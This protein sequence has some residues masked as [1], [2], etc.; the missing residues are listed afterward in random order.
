MFSRNSIEL[1]KSTKDIKPI[2]SFTEIRPKKTPKTQA[3]LNGY[4][5]QVTSSKHSWENFLESIKNI[6]NLS[7]RTV[8]ITNR[9]IFKQVEEKVKKYKVNREF[10]NSKATNVLI[11]SLKEIESFKHTILSKKNLFNKIHHEVKTKEA[12]LANLLGKLEEMNLNDF[13]VKNKNLLEARNLEQSELEAG[14][15]NELI[16]KKTLL[17]IAERIKTQNIS[18]TGPIVELR[19]KIAKVNQKIESSE[20]KFIMTVAAITE[21]DKTIEAQEKTYKQIIYKKKALV[22]EKADKYKEKMRLKL[23]IDNEKEKNLIKAKQKEN[24]KKL[25]VL[26]TKLKSFKDIEALELE[27]LSFESF[28][29]NEEEKFKTIQKITSVRNVGDIVNHYNYLMDN[30]QKLLDSVN[31]AFIQ[32]EKLNNNRKH[33]SEE[34]SELKYQLDDHKGL[35]ASDLE[36]IQLKF[37]EKINYIAMYENRLLKLQEIIV[38]AINTFSRIG[39]LLGTNQ[40]IGR[41]R[42]E[43][44][45]ESMNLCYKSLGS[46]IDE[47]KEKKENSSSKS[48]DLSYSE[49]NSNQ[50]YS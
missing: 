37:R 16:H 33:L 26:E 12:L 1:S 20:K 44:L 7:P 48:L 6:G 15:K 3:T 28:C 13:E 24:I 21:L 45:M 42:I 47:I 36:T 32:I 8:S 29:L 27:V 50:Y 2:F 9:E 10:S 31:L 49:V 35:E 19:K 38:L 34:L 39:D 46:I 25:K 43:N 4:R 41:I 5:S 22:S 14:L 30:K 40:K 23:S 11:K 18:N 17:H